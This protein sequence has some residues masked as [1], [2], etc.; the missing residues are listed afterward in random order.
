MYGKRMITENGQEPCKESMYMVQRI[1]R[2]LPAPTKQTLGNGFRLTV[3]TAQRQGFDHNILTLY[4][5]QLFT[6]C[7]REVCAKQYWRVSA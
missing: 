2:F 4:S 6:V 3:S 5:R 7:S 1:Q